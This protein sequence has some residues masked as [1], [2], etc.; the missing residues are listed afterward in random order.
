MQRFLVSSLVMAMMSVSGVALAQNS[1]VSGIVR[2]ASTGRPVANAS[3]VV[4]LN[5]GS[6]Q[7]VETSDAG[8]FTLTIEGEGTATLNATQSGYRLGAY[9]VRLS[10]DKTIIQDVSLIP[11]SGQLDEIVVTAEQGRGQDLGSLSQTTLSR[12]D[13]RRAP[14]TAGDIFRGLNSLPGV[15]STGEFSNFSVRGRGPRDNLILIDGIPY[16]RLVHFDQSLGEEDDLAGGGRF[17]IFG[18]NVVGSAEFAAGGWG[19]P[20]GGANGSF[21]NLELADGNRADPF[22]SVKVDLAGAELLYDGPMAGTEDTGLLVSARYYNFG[23]L[24]KIIGEKSIGAPKLTDIII[25]STTQVNLDTRVKLLAIYT[26]ESYT[27]DAENALASDNYEDASL[28]DQSLDTGLFGIVLESLVGQ[29]GQWQNALYGRFADDKTLVGEAYP[30]RSP[31]PVNLDNLVTEPDILS[32]SEE[33]LAFGWRSDY[34]QLNSFGTFRAGFEVE[35]VSLDF[36]QSVARDYA[37]FVYD[38][39]DFRASPDQKYIVLRPETF[40]ARLDES[41]LDGAVYVDQSFSF[42]QI[43]IRPGVRVNYNQLLDYSA[44]SPR[45]SVTWQAAAA[46]T[47]SF[48]AGRYDQDPRLL[49]VAANPAN[50]SLKPETSWQTSLGLTHYFGDDYKVLVEGYYQDLSNLILNEAGDRGTGFLTNDGDGWTAGFDT[51]LSKRFSDNWSATA[52]YSYAK[53]KRRANQAAA[54]LPAEFSR[55][56]WAGFTVNYELNDRW[57][58]AAQYNIAS[59]LPSDDYV[60]HQDVFNDPTFVRASKEITARKTGRSKSFQTLNVRVDYRRT[61]GGATLIA[62]VDVVNVLARKN[63]DGSD[64][65]PRTGELL[66]QGL[67]TFPQ[68]GLTIEF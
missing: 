59:G 16:D 57:A 50:I 2:D 17:S 67:T 37:Q 60:L 39:S 64:F 30:E 9:R 5:D 43:T 7:A 22:T 52:R 63:V 65:S 62:F 38:Q 29:S 51:V 36:A 40:N 53:T 35:H 54:Y 61:F 15:Q 23:Q 3:I 8:E 33:E 20:Y 26:P 18:Q 31:D 32:S 45:L 34:Q 27:R 25:K 42:D 58:F 41:S 19:A 55:P 28:V 1:T 49:E 6:S 66:E 44:I 24:F 11:D 48:T 10:M 47:L 68:L 13:I 14:G 56:H 12:E 46:T 4:R 21:L